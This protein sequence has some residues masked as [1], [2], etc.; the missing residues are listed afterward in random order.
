MPHGM[1]FL[2]RPELMTLHIVSDAFIALAYFTIPFAILRFVRG[3]TDLAAKHK[4]MA[5]LF[6]AFI[7]F[8]GLTH[9]VSIYVLWVPIYIFEGWLKAVTAIVS[10]ATAIG[11]TRLVPQVLKLPSAEAMRIEIEAHRETLTALDTA[12]AALS[13]RADR[14]EEALRESEEKFRS[15]VENM[16]EGLIIF[17][18]QGEVTFHNAA[19]TRIHGIEREAEGLY[20]RDVLPIHWHGRDSE[21]ATVPPE[22]WPIA[23]VLRGDRVQNQYLH[24]ECADTALTIDAVYNGAPIYGPDGHFQIGFITLRD[25]RDEIHGQRALAHAHD[26]LRGFTDAVPGVIYAKDRNGRMLFANDGLAELLGKPKGDVIGKTDDEFLNDFVEAEAV[27]AN[28]RRIMETGTLE[29]IEER[30]SLAN[31]A[32]AIWLSTKAPLRDAEGLVTGI[33]GLSVDISAQKEIEAELILL[34]NRL[35]SQADALTI[36]NGQLNDA[37]AQRNLL[38]REVYHRVKNN[39]QMVDSFLVLQKSAFSDPI[40]K[41]ALTGLR[42]RV[43]ALGLVHH[44][45]MQS[46]NLRTFDIAPFLRELADNIL[47]GST[48]NSVDISVRAETLVVDLDFAIPLA[49]LVTELVTNALKHAFPSGDGHIDV[50]LS[51]NSTG[52]FT[53]VVSDTGIGYAGLSTA[54]SGGLGSKIIMALVRQLKATMTLHAEHG[55]RVEIQIAATT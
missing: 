3:R 31:G 37:L 27:M 35:E 53:L 13:I 43:N 39:M 5:L 1:C 49:L 6:A 34:N 15:V 21:G 4:R 22:S 47:E 8:C 11:L 14:S 33:I 52:S 2:W 23:R 25:V 28:D 41:A 12:R 26:L 32:A 29:H 46:D 42:K 9:V 48:S 36:A 55:T 30:V 50:L 16:S 10:V 45:L 18:K 17:D 44:Q 38:L 54:S 51:R 24:A 20:R 7:A 40:T 19:S